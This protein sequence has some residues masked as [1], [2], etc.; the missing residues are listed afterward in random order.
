M[1]NKDCMDLMMFVQTNTTPQEPTDIQS[2]GH[3]V[4]CVGLH[5]RRALHRQ[6]QQQQ[7]RMRL[8][9]MNDNRDSRPMMDRTLYPPA[10]AVQCT[11]SNY[12]L[13]TDGLLSH[14]YRLD[15]I[16]PRPERTG[17]RPI[18]HD[19]GVEAL[20]ANGIDALR[21]PDNSIRKWGAHGVNE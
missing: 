19:P 21:R 17:Y 12:R 14:V 10:R 11:V 7:Q 5:R 18:H 4:N 9:V 3:D 6:Q 1:V 2:E 16:P 8:T 15:G 20:I 13:F